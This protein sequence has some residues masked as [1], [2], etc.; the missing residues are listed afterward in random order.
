MC[1][2]RQGKN[3]LN[4]LFK[5]VRVFKVLPVEALEFSEPKTPLVYS[6][7]PPTKVEP[8]HGTS[9]QEPIPAS[10]PCLSVLKNDMRHR[11][12]PCLEKLF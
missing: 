5:E 10:E 3:G 9:L 6:F 11:K 2:Y 7:F 4:S 1:Y 8:E 12:P